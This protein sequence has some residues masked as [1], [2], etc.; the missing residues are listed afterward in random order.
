[1]GFPISPRHYS[2]YTRKVKRKMGLF[3]VIYLIMVI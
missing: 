3:N 1:M 2:V